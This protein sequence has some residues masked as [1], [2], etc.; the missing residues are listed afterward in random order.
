MNIGDLVIVSENHP[1]AGES[2]VIVKKSVECT[3]CIEKTMVNVHWDSGMT[4]W[5][6]AKILRVIHRSEN[7]GRS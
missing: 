6:E 4:Y 2:G 3:C 1:S 7:A 5:V